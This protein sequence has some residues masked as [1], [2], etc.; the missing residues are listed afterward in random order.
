MVLII[1]ERLKNAPDLQP[2]VMVYYRHRPCSLRRARLWDLIEI[3]F[4]RR[5]FG[6][7]N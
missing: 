7:R 3:H 5:H 4:E 6:I 1:Q 2:Q